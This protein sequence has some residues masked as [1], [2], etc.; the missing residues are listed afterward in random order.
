MTLDLIFCGTQD[1]IGDVNDTELLRNS[2]KIHAAICF[3]RHVGG[4]VPSLSDMKTF[5]FQRADITQMR[6]LVRKKRKGKV[7]RVF[8]LHESCRSMKGEI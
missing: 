5:N 1:L 8:R 6:K 7:V 4:R 3:V 2:K